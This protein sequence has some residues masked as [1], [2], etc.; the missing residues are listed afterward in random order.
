MQNLFDEERLDSWLN[1]LRLKNKSENTVRAYRQ[2]VLGFAAWFE[3]TNGETLSPERVTPTDLREYKAYLLTAKKR[4]PDTVNLS[5]IA[6]ASW[7]KFHG[8]DVAMPHAVEQVRPAPQGLDRL[9]QRALM[10]TLER[11][12]EERN[13]AIVTFMLDTGLRISEVA[14]LDVDDLTLNER[15]G[16]VKVRKGKGGKFRTVSLNSDT[17]KAL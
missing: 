9:E 4:M 3:E 6:I 11:D 5:L 7:L 13:I 17:R 1:H 12:G 15:S 14:A 8:Q 2:R 16:S 10:R